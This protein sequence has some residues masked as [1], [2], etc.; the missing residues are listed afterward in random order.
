MY[1]SINNIFNPFQ[2]DLHDDEDD[3]DSNVKFS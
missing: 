1:I 3:D 2:W